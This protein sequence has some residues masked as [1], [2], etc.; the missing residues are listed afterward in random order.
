MGWMLSTQ[1]NYAEVEIYLLQNLPVNE[2]V[3]SLS[4]H[5]TE[6]LVTWRTV[7]CIGL[8]INLKKIILTNLHWEIVVN[9][10]L[11]KDYILK[12]N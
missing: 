3:D 8:A 4:G 12:Y 6:F 9:A 7:S 5:W 10:P 11:N 2:L 1:S